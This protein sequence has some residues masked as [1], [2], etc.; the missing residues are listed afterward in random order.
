MI[1]VLLR[2]VLGAVALVAL[3]GASALAAS[4][5]DGEWKVQTSYA[6]SR[7]PSGNF[8]ATVADGKMTGVYKGVRGSYN[9]TGTVTPDGSFTGSFGR[10]PLSGKF[11]GDHLSTTFAPPEPQ[12]E[13]GNLELERAK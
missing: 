2:S 5:Y 10:A 13:R 8:S 3:T 9:L 1:E 4:P 7:C 6:N 11:A 12:C